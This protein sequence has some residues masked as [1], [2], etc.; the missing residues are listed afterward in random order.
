MISVPEQGSVE[1]G[2]ILLQQCYFPLMFPEVLRDAVSGLSIRNSIF[3][4]EAT[5]LSAETIPMMVWKKSLERNGFKG[6][7]RLFTRSCTWLFFI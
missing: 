5:P 4:G 2:K 7:S 3:R 1:P 6:M